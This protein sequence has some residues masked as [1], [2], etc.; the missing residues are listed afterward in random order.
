MANKSAPALPYQ[1]AQVV[2][3]ILAMLIGLYPLFYFLQDKFGML[4]R[5]SAGLLASAFWL[6]AFYVHIIAGG[7]ALLAG[8]VQFSQKIRIA[9]PPLHRALGK[10]YVISALCSSLAAGYLSLHADGGIVATLGFLCLAI[11]WCAATWIGYTSILKGKKPAH[12]K[13][14]TFSYAACFAAVTLRL[15]LPLLVA[16]L[17]DFTQAYVFVAWLC[18]VPNMLVAYILT[19]NIKI[20]QSALA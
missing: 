14:M 18:W 12:K 16:V 5:K 4:A 19:R 7:L 20:N 17:Q 13:W 1:I 6:P 3:A 11:V 15:W 2:C 10:T 8:W 9:T